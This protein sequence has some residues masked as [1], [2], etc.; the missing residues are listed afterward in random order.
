[1][2]SPPADW[3]Q[4]SAGARRSV[5]PAV[6]EPTSCGAGA[7]GAPNDM[8]TIAIFEICDFLVM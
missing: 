2:P 1:M 8:V 3:T 4:W 5:V 7:T 6:H